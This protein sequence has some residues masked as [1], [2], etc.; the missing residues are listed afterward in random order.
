MS[1]ASPVHP[2]LLTLLGVAVLIGFVLWRRFQRLAGPQRLDARGRRR[3]VTN[4]L[5]LGGIALLLLLTAHG[6]P[7]YGADGLGLA[8]GALL[9]GWSLRHTR[10]ERDPDGHVT[11]YLPNAWIGGAV[12][13]LFALRLLWRLLPVLDGQANHAPASLQASFGGSAWTGALF[14]LFAGYQIVYQLLVLRQAR[15]EFL[16]GRPA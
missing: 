2:S 15:P 8:A 11:R 16:K 7:G 13:G 14:M 12:F 6:L 5:I 3:L 9:A 10:F 4:S 1:A